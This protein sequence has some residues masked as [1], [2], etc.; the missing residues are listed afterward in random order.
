M[1]NLYSWGTSPLLLS[2]CILPRDHT[3]AQSLY[4]STPGNTL[5]R[6]NGSRFKWDHG[7]G[8]RFGVRTTGNNIRFSLPIILC[9]I[10]ERFVLIFD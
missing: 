5:L 4:I 9:S 8:S 10:A 1:G 2:Y 6:L 7:V 3:I